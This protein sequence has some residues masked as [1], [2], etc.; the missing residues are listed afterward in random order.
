MNFNLTKRAKP[1]A[2]A[3][4]GLALAVS[5]PTAMAGAQAYANIS[6]SNF[7]YQDVSNGSVLELGNDVA[8]TNLLDQTQHTVT[9]FVGPGAGV[10]ASA[11]SD[12]DVT[13]SILLDPRMACVG[14]GCG[15]GTA[16]EN[17]FVRGDFNTEE[18]N[19]AD[20]FGA[21]SGLDLTSVGGAVDPSAATFLAE[22]VTQAGATDAA[23]SRFNATVA[24]SITPTNDLV[25]GLD[26]D[27]ITDLFV[28]LHADAN[29]S[30]IAQVNFDI[31]LSR[32]D[33]GEEI[34]ILGNL[35]VLDEII[36]VNGDGPNDDTGGQAVA[37]SL[38]TASALL[39]GVTYDLAYS[40]SAT[41][42]LTATKQVPEPSALAL[43]G[44][45]LLGVSFA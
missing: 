34:D 44:L 30:A 18:Y 39:A 43:L 24:F 17:T 6:F 22:A 26:F 33:T 45:G 13:D 1:L 14:P 11:A 19:R 20:S 2:A 3:V 40:F 32:Q 16:V 4:A 38:Q 10:D 23:S 8:V 9:R 5:A 29:G 41:A 27:A 12:T 7:L 42:D 36:S 37:I 35:N 15:A 28:G 21:G 31:S 25:L